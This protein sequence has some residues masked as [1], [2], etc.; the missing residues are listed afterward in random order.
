MWYKDLGQI[1]ASGYP[2]SLA[3]TGSLPSGVTFNTATGVLSGTPASGSS[4]TYPLTITAININGSVVTQA[5]TLTVYDITSDNNKVFT[6]GVAGTFT[7]TANLTSTFSLTGSLPSG[8]TFNT[9]TGV[10]S[11]TPAAGT[12]G[13]YPLTITASNGASPDA[14]QA[15]TLT[16]I[17]ADPIAPWAVTAT[18]DS[19]LTTNPYAVKHDGGWDYSAREDRLYA[20]YGLDAGGTGETLYCID[21]IGETS[22]TATTWLYGR[23]GSHP[24]IDDT[25][26]YVYAPPSEQTYQL[27]RY[28]TVTKVRETVAP[29]PNSTLGQFSHGA[30]KNSKLWIV[31]NNGNL[32]SYDPAANTWS[33]PLYTFS[34]G[35]ANVATSGPASNLIYVIVTG[36]T[37]YSY[38]VTTGVTTT[39]PSHP[40]GFSLGGNGQFT[41]FGATVGFIYACS[42]AGGTPAIYDIA[43][44]TWHA[45]SDPHPGG[46]WAGH[47][48]YDSS[49]KRLYVTGASNQVWY[50]QY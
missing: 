20:T 23:H 36:G 7:V 6:E 11:G 15:F 31:L 39:L 24:V 44:S 47:A 21:H 4:G 14:T 28:N 1:R 30:W 25:G 40:T 49:R 34:S 8:V 26:T 32:Y 9:A 19:W 13:T 33:T 50:Y 46:S 16:V 38:D 17:A 22:T 29:S 45:L 3:L 2:T 41:W 10:L 18:Y 5:F 48:T 37:F 43:N 35:Y 42:G 12:N 27:E